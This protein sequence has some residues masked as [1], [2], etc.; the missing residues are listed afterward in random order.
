MDLSIV[1][2][3]ETEYNK[4]IKL[5]QE[6]QYAECET[7]LK[8]ILEYIPDNSDVLN[9]YGRLKQFTSNFDE[10]I[11]ILEKSVKCDN[12]NFMG[13]YNL[14]LAYCIKKDLKKTKLHF[15]KYQ[16]LNTDKSR[17]YCNLYLSKLHFDELDIEETKYYYNKSNIPLFQKLSI[18]LIPRVYESTEQ[19]DYYRKLYSESLINIYNDCDDIIV[20]SNDVFTEY[21]Q[22]IY[23]YGFPLSYQGKNN[24][25]ILEMQCKL[26]RKIFPCLNYTSPY[27]DEIKTRPKTKIKIGFISTN[28]FN[29]SVSRDRMG[30]IRNLPR[31]LFDV[32]VFFYF[33]PSDD[34]GNFIWNS[35]NT[36]IVLPDS[37]IFERRTVIEQQKLD[38]L[39]YCDIGMAPDTYFLA[40][41]KLA[42]VQCNTWGHSD[43][44]GIDT[45]DYYL[46]SIYYEKEQPQENYSEKLVLLDSLCTFY[47]K[48]IEQP[49]IVNKNHFAFSNNTNIYLSS[50]VLFKLNPDF[51]HIINNILN[52]D[53][54][55]VCVFIKMNLGS[56]IQDIIINRMEKVLKH[57]MTRVH[58]IEWQ[59]CERDFYKLLS[60]ADVIIDPY[61]F[62]GCNTSFS[63]FSMGIPIV[64]KPA[65]CINGRFTHGLYKKMN[66]LDLVANT[67]EEYV[68]LANKCAMD[69]NFRKSISNKI[70]ENIDLIFNEPASV[71][72]WINFAV[73]VI[74][75]TIPNT[76]PIFISKEPI[77]NSDS[78]KQQNTQSDNKYLEFNNPTSQITTNNIPKILHFIHF[79]YTEFT[80]I[81]Y[82]AIKT[83]FDN[84]TDYNIYLYNY[85]KPNNIWFQLASKYITEIIYT[86]PPT[87][88]FGN[89]IE[90]FAHKADIIRLQKLIE[91]GGIYL[92]IDVWT[93]KS[94]DSLLENSKSCIMG[95]Q[96]KN[97]QYEGL[98]NAVIFA[99]PQSE[100]LQLWLANYKSFNKE[101]WDVHSVY[102]PLKLSELNPS[103]ID[104][105]PQ[106]FFFPFSWF[107][108]DILFKKSSS[109]KLLTNSYCI[110]LWETHLYEPLLNKISPSYFYIYNTPLANI[111]S[112]NIFNKNN[113]S[114]LFIIQSNNN[115]YLQKSIT[116]IHDLITQG[117]NIYIKYTDEDYI[118]ENNDDSYILLNTLKQKTYDTNDINIVLYYTD[119]IYWQKYKYIHNCAF[120]DSIIVN[121]MNDFDNIDTILTSNK[122]E[123]NILQSITKNVE[124]INY[125]INNLDST[126]NNNSQQLKEFFDT[127]QSSFKKYNNII[128]INKNIYLETYDSQPLINVK[129]NKFI[130][131]SFLDNYNDINN[132]IQFYTDFYNKYN[133]DNILLYIYYNNHNNIKEINE[134][135]DNY[136]SLEIN[137]PIILNFNCLSQESINIIH[138]KSSVYLTLF[139]N[140][141]SDFNAIYSSLYN[142]QIITISNNSIISEYILNFYET[143][144]DNIIDIMNYTYNNLNTTLLQD[145]ITNLQKYCLCDYTN[146]FKSIKMEESKKKEILMIGKFS[147]F[148]N[149]MDTMYFEFLQYFKDNSNYD[150]VF[151]DTDNCKK[152]QQLDYYI[153]KYCKTTNPIIYN[154]VYT[155]STEQI[156]SNLSETKLTTIYEI[157]D[158]Y[159]I[160]LLI[161]NINNF[162]Y[163]YVIY[164]YN[165][166]Q[167][168]YIKSKSPNTKFL[169]LPHYI[170]HKFFNIDTTIPKK[171]D[172]LLYGN[173]SNFYPFRQRLFNLIINAGFNYYHLEHP[174]YN[175]TNSIT[176]N[177]L[178]KL[179]NQSKL[180]IST[181]SAF[182]YFLKKYLEISMSG[183]IIAGN[184]P[185]TEINPYINSMCLLDET[186]SDNTI[187]SKL[188]TFINLSNNDYN[189]I[190][191]NSYEYTKNN[192]LYS[193]GILTLDNIIDS[194]DNN[195]ENNKIFTYIYEN[196]VWHENGGSGNGSTIEFNKDEYIPFVK[197]FI[198]TH[199]INTVTDLGCGDWQSS[200][201]IYDD[202]NV[203][204]T[205]Y[206]V[207]ENI[208]NIN[209]KKFPNYTFKHLDFIEN[210]HILESTD[211]CIIKD[212]LQHL[213]TKSIYEFLDYIVQKKVYKYILI[214]NC[215][216]QQND[217]DDIQPGEWRQLSALKFPLKKYN[218]TILLNYNTKQVS[219]ITL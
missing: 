162:K 216:E 33:K 62:G 58:F 124:Y 190:I 153:T 137:S 61:P 108:F 77:N 18:L 5:F 159:E 44:S 30:I 186:M 36:N 100:F 189:T 132:L 59:K 17:F 119:T 213:P 69:K 13:H 22:F 151:V 206:D 112:K 140:N 48:I 20:K 94:Y 139:N 219:L 168:D 60:M 55:G 102:L 144:F 1:N 34:L 170:N 156:I 203:K 211:L 7:K 195:T 15:E 68:N 52:N 129:S 23:C 115:N 25:D 26:Y 45:I 125:P 29:Q 82:Y 54:N 202:L 53:P 84:N 152:N 83:A 88:I 141:Y 31:E 80:F 188:K 93:N 46:S 109:D 181:S 3:L 74:N 182:N 160:D 63:A 185:S 27:L 78:N 128:S 37:S 35:Q 42:P 198:N 179:I 51:D 116:Y 166:E 212:V 117:Y 143:K 207:Y 104:I 86:I 193:N 199:Y 142:N 123:L 73:E 214:I 192:L 67:N 120:Y 157:E 196:K 201:L 131:Y 118:L 169:H 194:M 164:R 111:F 6:N 175:N 127:I 71:N 64:T 41:S 105:K 148:K 14:G 208:I 174:G 161:N 197:K 40:Y 136:K 122:S 19:I 65:Q 180:T 49:Q 76:S 10:S 11:E 24:K 2:N 133:Y 21:L 98:C 218:P 106:E 209:N 177:E 217:D 204:Y 150:I 173:I 187:I 91:H 200:Y 114:I 70:L 96:C 113:Q 165:C 178:S 147:S 28:F 66:I 50:Q 87:E 172:I 215:C 47:Y 85:I 43:T 154:I 149:R 32:T 79:G 146:I 130:Y 103:L 57:N 12:N 110:H 167:M 191:N 8:Y 81:H 16:E 90:S 183:S 163:D 171:Y 138:Q 75:N 38:I 99:K 210:K 121:N 97:T 101:Q 176:K 56:Y 9:F 134:I 89:Q 155:H 107:D 184:F 4:A 39:V 92:D 126:I 72:T 205:G 158:C 135:I 95:Y 145:N